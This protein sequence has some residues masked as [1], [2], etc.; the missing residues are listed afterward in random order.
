MKIIN[1]IL[2]AG[3]FLLLLSMERVQKERTGRQAAELME[4]IEFKKARNQYLRY[5]TGIYNS[6]DKIIPAAQERGLVM[7]PAANI[8]ILQEDK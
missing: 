2:A 8:I 7:T 5:K 1:I 3:L 4:D 6:P